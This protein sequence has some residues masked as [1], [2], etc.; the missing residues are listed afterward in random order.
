LLVKPGLACG[1]TDEL[2]YHAVESRMHI[3]DFHAILMVA[4]GLD[5]INIQLPSY[6]ARSGECGFRGN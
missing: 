2:G 4:M 5:Q 1:A 3:Y 6:L